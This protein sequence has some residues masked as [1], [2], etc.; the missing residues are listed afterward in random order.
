[1]DLLYYREHAKCNNYYSEY[2]LG[3]L[4]RKYERGGKLKLTLTKE[5]CVV[6]FRKG[7][8]KII[9]KRSNQSTILNENMMYLLKRFETY[10]AESSQPIEMTLLFFDY[11]KVYCDKFTL[12][13]LACSKEYTPSDKTIRALPIKKPL[14]SFIQNIDFYLGNRMYCRH[15]QDIKQSEWFFLMKGFYTRKEN[16][17]F[18]EPLFDSLDDFTSLVKNNFLKTK[19]VK[20][21][22]GFC[23][24]GVKTFTRRFKRTFNDTPKQ[25]M[26]KE[27]AKLENYEKINLDS[28][29]GKYHHAY[30]MEKH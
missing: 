11:P 10:Y 16:I 9:H 22:A 14:Q 21:L 8:A 26:L 5:F 30:V 2:S 12:N 25:W 19:S 1:M 13:D 24:M 27:K 17:Y 4:H 20:E 29:N 23:N 28:E 3:F 7:N 18:F 6:F 15:L